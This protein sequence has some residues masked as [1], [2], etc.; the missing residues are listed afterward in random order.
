MGKSHV[1]KLHIMPPKNQS[2]LISLFLNVESVTS[3]IM[4]LTQFYCA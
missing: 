2:M 3:F 4:S 1:G